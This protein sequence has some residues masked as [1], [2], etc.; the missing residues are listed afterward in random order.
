MNNKKITS[1]GLI[2]HSSL[3]MTTAGTPLGLLDKKI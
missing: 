3:A 1:W 2:M